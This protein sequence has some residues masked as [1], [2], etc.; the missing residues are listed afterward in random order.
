MDTSCNIY[1]KERAGGRGWGACMECSDVQLEAGVAK[2][3]P[4][5][6]CGTA[7][8]P[9]GPIDQAGSVD[10]QDTEM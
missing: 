5:M 8:M 3:R 4:I 10:I 1:G 9:E 2:S 7:P 6:E